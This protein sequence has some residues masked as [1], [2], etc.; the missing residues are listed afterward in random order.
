MTQKYVFWLENVLCTP[1]LVNC[2]PYTVRPLERERNHPAYFDVGLCFAWIWGWEM[3][4]GGSPPGLFNHPP[5]PGRGGSSPG[6]EGQPATEQSMPL[7]ACPHANSRTDQGV[8]SGSTC[9]AARPRRNRCNYME[10]LLS[11]YGEEFF[12]S[13]R[14][15]SLSTPL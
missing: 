15:L 2:A 8:N 4:V 13:Y 7:A 9:L 1:T 6:W 10:T 12:F 3:G 5:N 14:T 11:D